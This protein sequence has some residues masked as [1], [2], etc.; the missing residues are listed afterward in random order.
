MIEAFIEA[1]GTAIRD[2][3]KEVQLGLGQGLSL[4]HGGDYRAYR[5]REG[6]SNGHRIGPDMPLRGHGRPSVGFLEEGHGPE[7]PTLGL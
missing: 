7:H 2:P 5:R 1:F 3:L 6:S 4:C